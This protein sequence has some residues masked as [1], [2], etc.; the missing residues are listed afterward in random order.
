MIFAAAA[1]LLATNNACCGALIPFTLLLYVSAAACLSPRVKIPASTVSLSFLC[2]IHSR[3][4]SQCLVNKLNELLLVVITSHM[5]TGYF[6]GCDIWLL[7]PWFS[8][9]Q[10]HPV[11]LVHIIGIFFSLFLLICKALVL[12]H[13]L[14]LAFGIVLCVHI[15]TLTHKFKYVI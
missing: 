3:V 4:H 8:V 15:H 6:C 11:A 10:N 1:A 13:Y 14:I 7:L 2:Y 9:V 12:C 5:W